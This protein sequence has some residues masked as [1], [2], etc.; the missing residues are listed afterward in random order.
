MSSI[1]FYGADLVFV[2]DDIGHRAKLLEVFSQ[3]RLRGPLFETFDKHTVLLLGLPGGAHS[4]QC[5]V[6]PTVEVLVQ[7]WFWKTQVDVVNL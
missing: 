4:A 2:H 5:L 1:S 7:A 6:L 3:V